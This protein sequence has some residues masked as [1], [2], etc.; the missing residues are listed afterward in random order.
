MQI[1]NFF[2]TCKF[3][4]YVQLPWVFPYFFLINRAPAVRTLYN[5]TFGV[6]SEW[7]QPKK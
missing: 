5:P 7:K 2:F 6:V 1:Y 4:L 3:F